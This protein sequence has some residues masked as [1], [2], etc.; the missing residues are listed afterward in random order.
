MARAVDFD[1]D[2]DAEPKAARKELIFLSP[3]LEGTIDFAAASNIALT[4]V[5]FPPAM[6][7]LLL[8]ADEELEEDGLPVELFTI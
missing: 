5:L 8:L 1:E 7:T 4:P 6:A 2:V 3:C